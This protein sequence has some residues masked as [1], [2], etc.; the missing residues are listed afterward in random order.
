MPKTRAQ[1][2]TELKSLINT[3][4]NNK[5][6]VLAEFTGLLMGELEDFRNKAREIGVC[7]RIVKNTLLTK[8]AKD[9]DID[10]DIRKVGKQIAIANSE[11]DE[12]AVSKVVN[13]LAKSSNNRVKIF[14]GIIEKEIVSIDTIIKLANLPSRE[15]LLARVVGS[16]YAP[17]SG[18]VRTLN[19]PLQG[20][21]NVINSLKES[22]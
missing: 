14:S 15:E 19:N 7:F 13:E 16:I 8:A 9:L 10:L 18:L 12:V 5:A 21:Y 20:F 2:E 11:D 3:L 22:K 17:V 6:I 4:K 1:K